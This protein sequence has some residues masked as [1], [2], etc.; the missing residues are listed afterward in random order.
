MKTL[1]SS[2]AVSTRYVGV[3]RPHSLKVCRAVQTA[4]PL[5]VVLGWAG[6]NKIATDKLTVAN[7]VATD[8]PVLV[9]AKDLPAGDA[10]LQVPDSAWITADTAQKAAIGKYIGALEPWLQLTLLLLAEKGQPGS[11]LSQYISSLPSQP[12]SPLFWS[13]EELQMLEGTQL[14]ESVMGYK[15]FFF[16]QYQSLDEQLFSP[17]RAAFP[18]ERFSY[19]SFCWAVASVRSRLH[20]PLDA[21]PVALVPLADALPHRRNA[22]A[23][24]KLKSAGLFGKGKVLSVEATR[25]VRKGE[26]VVMDYGPEK[27]DNALLL[28]HGV[29]DASSAKGGYSLTLTLPEDDRYFAD[30]ADI[31]ERNGLGASATFGLVRGQEPS[32]EMMGFLRLMQLS[33]S[34]CF[35]LESIFEAEAWSHMCQPVSAA[36]EAAVCSAMMDGARE[37]LARYSSSIDEDLA[38]LRDGGVVAGSRQETA[39]QVRLGEQE[40]LDSLLGFFEGRAADLAALEYYQ[41]R[42]LKRLGLMDEEGKTT[43][44]SFFKDGIA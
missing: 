38:L 25:A 27:L 1:K 40:A 10:V 17:N 3:G 6:S 11:S 13:D 39:V 32:L 22:N 19:G 29:L 34:D 4:D 7:D 9:A 15:Q 14:L 41:E 28:D 8:V 12:N 33:G 36:N 35:L 37:A 42:R 24:W 5:Q 16:E 26:A 43:Y 30:K 2:H 31:L 44:D 20:A 23:A 21:D 18:V